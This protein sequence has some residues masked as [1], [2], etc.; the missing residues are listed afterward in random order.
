MANTI[1]DTRATDWQQLWVLACLQELPRW[2]VPERLKPVESVVSLITLR[3]ASHHRE[4][5]ARQ[6][7]NEQARFE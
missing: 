7:E 4:R 6:P 5:A 2:K 1:T 3:R